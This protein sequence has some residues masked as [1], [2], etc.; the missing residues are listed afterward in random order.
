MLIVSSKFQKKN[1]TI[2]AKILICSEL[3]NV[4]LCNFYIQSFEFWTNTIS[5]FSDTI[6]HKNMWKKFLLKNR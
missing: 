6:F 2:Y 3:R 1:I 4:R 5:E